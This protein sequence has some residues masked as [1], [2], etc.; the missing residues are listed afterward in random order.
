MRVLG[1]EHR[2]LHLLG[3]GIMKYMMVVLAFYEYFA[4]ISITMMPTSRLFP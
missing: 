3:K 4:N 2:G 1:H